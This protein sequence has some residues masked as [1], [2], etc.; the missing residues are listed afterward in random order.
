MERRSFL[1]GASALGA[2]GL[3]AG[4]LFWRWQRIP[5]EVVYPGRG[6][7]HRLRDGALHPPSSRIVNADVMILGS[8]VAGLTAAWKLRKEGID[9][10]VM[11]AGPELY[12]NAAAGRFDSLSYPTGA[13]YLPLPSIESTH[14]REMLF[15][16]GVIVRDPDAQRPTYDER[17]VLH[18]PG[19][20]VLYRNRWEEGYEP[21]GK[22]ALADLQEHERFFELIESFT[23]ARGDDG[24]RPFVIPIERSSSDPKWTAL[25]Q[26]S[27]PEW[28]DAQGFRSTMLRWYLDYCCRDD[29][30]RHAHEISAWAGLHYFCARAGLAENAQRGAV[31]TWPEGLHALAQGLFESAGLA[32]RLHRGSA[33]S[34]TETALGV[35]AKCVDFDASPLASY[36]VRARRA[37]VALPLYVAH[38]VVTDLAAWGFSAQRDLPSYA[39][40]LVSN[41]L[42]NAFPEEKGG[43]A[44]AWDNVAV[45]ETGLGYVIST[46]QEIRQSRPEQAVFS[47][48][49][50]LSDM[51]P[52]AARRWLDTARP[53]ELLEKAAAD[54]RLAYGWKLAPCVA[55]VE[56]TVRAH[57]MAVPAPGFL[58]NPGRLALRAAD[59][60]ILFAHGDLSGLSVFEE[61]AWW[62]Y[63]A[64]QKIA[65]RDTST[66]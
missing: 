45:G 59:G 62:G 23:N 37:I 57:A 16:L 40:W 60:P 42:M 58:S 34:V 15:D 47:A 49:N 41:F 26:Q 7:G 36:T 61:A 35:E 21:M 54:L 46:H 13:H 30:G 22:L 11:V 64:A 19:E 52:L 24:R 6:A 53:D 4:G 12:G 33:V 43:A 39:P 55:R 51:D 3:C 2:L 14:M 25:D 18:A 66:S 10:F 20:R 29:Y 27:F 56:I 65:S 31:L 9:D 44:L 48:Y 63:R 32:K 50:A 28:L 38:H 8:G 17:Y 5:V 1:I